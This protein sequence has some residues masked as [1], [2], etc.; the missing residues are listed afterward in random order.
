M[1]LVESQLARGKRRAGDDVT[2]LSPM[3]SHGLAS[4]VSNDETAGNSTEK[5]LKLQL[6]L[7][8][9]S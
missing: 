5:S 8:T 3:R 6:L 7:G 2:P 4:T 1:P 9:A